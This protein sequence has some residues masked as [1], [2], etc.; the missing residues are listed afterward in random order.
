MDI[1]KAL[2]ELHDEKRRVD[3][4]IAVLEARI[5]AT[6]GASSRPRRG[7]SSMS[8]QARREVSQRMSS[9]WA[10]RQAQARQLSPQ[11]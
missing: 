11:D 10:A 1:D 6:P 2:S 4:A 9:Y 5:A 3:A 8:S 7:R